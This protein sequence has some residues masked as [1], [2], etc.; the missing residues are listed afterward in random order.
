[1]TDTPTQPPEGLD[2]ILF[3]FADYIKHHEKTGLG[4]QNN[5]NLIKV[6]LLAWRDAHT[7]E[8]VRLAR[9]DEL[10]NA[11]KMTTGINNSGF[12]ARLVN[13]LAELEKEQG[14]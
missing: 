2:E 11:R 7:R 6:K 13:R 5:Q 8:A 4:G 14:K 10:K 12:D 9:I 3:S 1:M